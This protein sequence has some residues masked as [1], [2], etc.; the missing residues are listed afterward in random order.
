MDYL[1]KSKEAWTRAANFPTNKECV[2]TEHGLVQE[3]DAHHD[4]NVLEYGCGGGS[5][6]I[7][8]LRRN[9][10]VT[11]CDIVPDNIKAASKNVELYGL[12]NFTP[13]LLPTSIPLPFPDSVFDIVN[14]HGV[15]H[16][17]PYAKDVVKELYRVTKDEGLCY[18]M[19]Y[20]EFLY[21]YFKKSVDQLML[22]H[23]ISEQEAFSWMTDGEGTPYADW[24]D[25]DAGIELLEQAG[26]KV[27][28]A[29][30]WLNN[31]FRTFKAIKS[32]KSS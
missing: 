1:N 16:H 31:H 32:V 20:T 2:Y 5:D 22:A 21:E 6:A 9:N 7:S 29:T 11:A 30:A 26:Y 15:L 13:V 17:I 3:F 19:L 28:M 27:L 12:S 24:Y 4:K 14:S 25:E 23:D 18:I 10:K 8:Y